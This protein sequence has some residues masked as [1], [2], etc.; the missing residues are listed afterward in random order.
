[1]HALREL[2]LTGAPVRDL[3]ALAGL[4]QLQLL[5]LVGTPV[6]D[7]EVASLADTVTVLRD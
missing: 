1:L 5:V 2:D 6:G 3:S 7:E 4:S